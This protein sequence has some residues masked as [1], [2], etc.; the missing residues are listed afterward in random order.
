LHS[1]EIGAAA[2]A[3]FQ[4]KADSIQFY[5]LPANVMGASFCRVVRSDDLMATLTIYHADGHWSVRGYHHCRD[6]SA[7]QTALLTL[8]AMVDSLA[9]L[10]RRRPF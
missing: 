7:Q 1:S 2:L 9:A 4:T 8:E 10:P 6:V 3:V 5:A